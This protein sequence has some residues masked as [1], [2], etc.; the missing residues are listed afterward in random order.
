MRIQGPKSSGTAKVSRET[1]EQKASNAAS[2]K[3]AE[4]TRGEKVRISSQAKQLADV[5]APEKPDME[6]VERLKRAIEDGSFEIDA[7]KIADR[8]LEEEI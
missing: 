4:R 5:R 2:S 6:R 8:M 7:E 3:G 1:A